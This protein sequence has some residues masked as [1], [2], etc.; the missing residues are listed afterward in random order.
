[1]RLSA[2]SRKRCVSENI[3][4]TIVIIKK[5]TYILFYVQDV[6]V[7]EAFLRAFDVLSRRK[8]L[9]LETAVEEAKSQTQAIVK[10]AQS[11]LDMNQIVSAGP[12][13][14]CFIKEVLL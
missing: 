10:Q 1:M 2:C 3:G 4:K 9:Q 14:Y 5:K 7:S 6:D 11:F 13:L 12:F 8:T